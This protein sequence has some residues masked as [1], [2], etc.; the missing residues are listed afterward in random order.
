MAQRLEALARLA[1]VRAR[2][3][4]RRNLRGLVRQTQH[5][6]F[7]ADRYAIARRE[8]G[9]AVHAATVDEE[10]VRALLVAYA[11]PERVEEE[12]GVVTGNAWIFHAN[13]A[14]RAAADTQCALRQRHCMRAELEEVPRHRLVTVSLVD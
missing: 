14:P 12:R 9:G 8:D 4:L 3:L 5:A 2:V 7:A 6:L 1:E 13:I 10:T 11:K